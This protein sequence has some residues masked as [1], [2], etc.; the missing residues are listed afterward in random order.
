MEIESRRANITTVSVWVRGGK[1]KERDSYRHPYS[2]FVC[3]CVRERERVCVC[4]C[5]RERER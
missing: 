5:K 2:R 4:V 3:V 1:K